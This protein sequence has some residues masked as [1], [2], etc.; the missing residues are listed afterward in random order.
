MAII[1]FASAGGSIADVSVIGIVAGGSRW[2]I[3]DNGLA[4]AATFAIAMVIYC[5]GVVIIA[6]FTLWLV[7]V[8]AIS[9]HTFS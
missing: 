1:V 2:I 6:G 5:T 7:G 8:G 3:A 9:G 4:E